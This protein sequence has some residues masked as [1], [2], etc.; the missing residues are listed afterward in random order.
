MQIKV[1]LQ[2]YLTQYSPNGS[3]VFDMEV[4]EGATVQ[5]VIK[6][7]GV[8]EEMTSVIVV[9]EENG[10]P[11]TVLADGDKLTLIPPLAGG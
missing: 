8:P 7:L 9:N 2:A 6:R 5:S 11:E 10:E 1:E 4:T 3:G